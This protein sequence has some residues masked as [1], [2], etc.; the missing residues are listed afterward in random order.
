MRYALSNE[1]DLGNIYQ[2]ETSWKYRNLKMLEM[3]IF[4]L[5]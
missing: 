4:A 1:E 5:W 2:K 3:M